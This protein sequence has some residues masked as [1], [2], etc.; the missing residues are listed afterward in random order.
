MKTNL[1]RA[2]AGKVV[3]RLC[4]GDHFTAKCPYKDSLAGLDSSADAPPPGDDEPE[5][6]PGGAGAGG[7]GGGTTTAT[8]PR[9]SAPAYI[10]GGGMGYS[11]RAGMTPKP[12]P[13]GMYA[14][15]TPGGYAG[16]GW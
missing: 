6:A 7:G 5:P 11:W 1:A 3:C 8:A 9:R 2:G 16:C 10:S 14:T 12:G 4:K 15:G 13:A